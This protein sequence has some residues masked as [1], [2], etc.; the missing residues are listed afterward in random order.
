MRNNTIKQIYEELKIKEV[1]YID[2][3]ASSTVW[4]CKVESN[5]YSKDEIVAIKHIVK[6]R[7]NFD[8]RKEIEIHKK[9]NS[10]NI[11][12]LYDSKDDGDNIWILMEH[13]DKGNLNDYFKNEIGNMK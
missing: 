7:I 12:K 3:G 13:C 1:W 2:K 9:L 10:D 11:V 5:P 4:G 8:W 6:A